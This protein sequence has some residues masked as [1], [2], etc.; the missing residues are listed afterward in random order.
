MKFI[1]KKSQFSSLMLKCKNGDAILQYLMHLIKKRK[2]K[3]KLTEKTQDR[4]GSHL[5]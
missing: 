2:N 4:R 5:R 3:I 1:S